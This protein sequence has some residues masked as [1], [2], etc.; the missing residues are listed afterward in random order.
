MRKFLSSND[1]KYRL[2]RTIVQ[3]IIGCLVANADVL[4][5]KF[6]IDPM[7]KTLIV[8]LTMAVLSPIMAYLGKEKEDISD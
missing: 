6:V 1:A 8:G 5:G 2:Y 7:W 3:S 4:I